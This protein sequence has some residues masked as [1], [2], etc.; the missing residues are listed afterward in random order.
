ESGY[1]SHF[2]TP[3]VTYVASSGD[4]GTV[5]WPAVSTKVLGV[6]GTSLTLTSQNNWS[7]ETG[8]SGSGGGKSVYLSEPSYQ[9]N[10]QSSGVRET[11]D[12][13]YNAD[14]NTGVYVYDSY[15]TYGS[16]WFQIG[17]TSAGSP[18]WAALIAIAN[19]G[20][21]LLGKSALTGSTGTLPAI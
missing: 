11:P 8:W 18:Q 2:S 15:R 5:S 17:G 16:H 10:A 19:Q 1:D 12:V 3:G 20:R 9:A 4:G 6:G 14:P 13:A 7:S 21:A